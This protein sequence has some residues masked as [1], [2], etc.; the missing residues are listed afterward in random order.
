MTP[1]TT[2]STLVHSFYQTQKLR[3]Q[4]GNRLVAQFRRDLGQAPGTAETELDDE[5]KQILSDFRQVYAKMSDGMQGALP[6]RR[7]FK[8]EGSITEYALLVLVKGYV[9]LETAENQ[10]R[11][12]IEATVKSMPLYKTFLLNV[13]GCGPVMSAI[14]LTYLD[15]HK[16]KYPSSFWKYCGLDVASDG[17]GRGRYKEHLE[18]RTFTKRDGTELEANVLTYNAFVRTKLLGVLAP[19]MLKA[20]GKSPADHPYAKRYYEYKTRLSNHARQ[21]D[22]KTARTPLHIHRCAL[23]YMIKRFLVDLYIA[24]RTQEGLTVHPE[25]AE[26]KL[27]YTH[28]QDI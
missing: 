12:E 5:A 6:S 15:P 19:G 2:L 16:A 17:R 26:A 22:K 9:D 11:S 25:Y 7:T 23:R 21:Q 1:Q 27:G 8:G 18:P 4:M 14:I 20:A 3:I 24:W 13:K 28:G 10:I